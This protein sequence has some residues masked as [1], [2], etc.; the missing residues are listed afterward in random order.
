LFFQFGE[1]IQS[2]EGLELVEVGIAEL[3]QHGA[4]ERREQDGLGSV[5]VGG[6]LG[7]SWRKFFAE[8]VLTLLV[9]L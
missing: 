9:P 2:I 3:V 5:A 8:L 4:V 7:C 1:Q 6:G